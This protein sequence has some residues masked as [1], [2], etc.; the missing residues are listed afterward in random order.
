MRLCALVMESYMFAQ[1]GEYGTRSALWYKDECAVS[2]NEK[3]YKKEKLLFTVALECSRPPVLCLNCGFNNIH[4]S[5]CVHVCAQLCH[6]A[7][8]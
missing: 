2:C 8:L 5:V 6:W 1:S 4:V 3:L 7:C